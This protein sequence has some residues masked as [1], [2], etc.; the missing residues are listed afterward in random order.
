[1]IEGAGMPIIGLLAMLSL[2][3]FRAEALA[4]EQGLDGSGKGARESDSGLPAT[5][6]SGESRLEGRPGALDLPGG[7]PRGIDREFPMT[8]GSDELPSQEPPG[9]GRQD[10]GPRERRRSNEEELVFN[11]G[12]HARFSV[13]FGAA[14]R[15][16]ATYPGGYYA[17]Y[18]YLSWA[19]LFNAGWGLELEADIFFGQNGPGY[20][21]HPG[22]NY[23]VAL[24]LQ[25]DE[26]T[27]RNNTDSF[28]NT[29]SLD[30]MTATSLQ[31]GVK[32]I[33]A[34]QSGFYLEGMIA[35]GAIHYSEVDGSFSG[36]AFVKFRDVIFEDTYTIASTFKG[37]GGYRVG[38]LGFVLDI[39]LRIM[40]PPNTGRIS[41]NSGAFWT[42]DI[43]LG[44]E[45]GF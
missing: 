21:R 26:F 23:G 29:L 40:A 10:T 28:G 6:E 16:Y 34:Q 12:L 35:V 44:V 9:P 1:M 18:N 32:M 43:N 19:D 25:A 31:I 15:S 27:G 8:L 39:G 4:Q 17:V 5:L 42:F 30:N 33:H 20:N 24:I 14:D 38:P 13:P 2:S 11:L 36:P 7:S 22:F 45:L 3:T 37:G 41:M